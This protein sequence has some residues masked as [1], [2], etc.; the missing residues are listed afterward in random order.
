[1]LKSFYERKDADGK[2][3]HIIKPSLQ[4]KSKPCKSKAPSPGGQPS[5]RVVRFGDRWIPP[6]TLADDTDNYHNQVLGDLG[7]L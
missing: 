2:W 6:A 1:M 4:G 7:Y 5:D 3:L